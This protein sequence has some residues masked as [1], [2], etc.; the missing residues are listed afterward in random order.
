MGSRLYT[1]V[2][3]DIE[4]LEEYEPYKRKLKYFSIDHVFYS[5]E[6]FLCY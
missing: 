2:P 6:E 4:K 5:V 1:R 3:I